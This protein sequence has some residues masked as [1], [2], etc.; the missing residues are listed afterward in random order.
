MTLRSFVAVWA[1]S[2]GLLM[3]ALTAQEKEHEPQDVTNLQPTVEKSGAQK[4]AND[5]SKT[6]EAQKETPPIVTHHE[7]HVG[8][9]VL[10]YTATTGMMPIRNT[11]NDEI[12][13]NIF[14][15]AY[16]LDNAGPNRPRM[17]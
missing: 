12:E 3:T 1:V 9:K 11:E 15:V 17:F 14:F 16:T 2:F 13:A 5:A 4:P 10:H 8:G 6:A 7:I